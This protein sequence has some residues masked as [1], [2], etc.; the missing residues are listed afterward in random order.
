MNIEKAEKIKKLKIEY[1]KTLDIYKYLQGKSHGFSHLNGKEKEQVKNLL[2][3][4]NS[5]NSHWGV[6]LKAAV[7]KFFEIYIGKLE[8]EIETE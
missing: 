5:G 7:V 8:K 1:D 6:P 2:A 4:V 3:F